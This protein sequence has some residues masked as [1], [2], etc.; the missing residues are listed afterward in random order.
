MER[1]KLR[2]DY[3]AILILMFSGFLISGE[4][5]VEKIE[6]NITALKK[7][8]NDISGLEARKTGYSRVRRDPFVPLITPRIVSVSDSEPVEEA[9]AQEFIV[10]G[11]LH[12]SK[13]SFAI[14][15][16]EVKAEGDFIENCRIRRIIDDNVLLQCDNTFFTVSMAGQE[17]KSEDEFEESK[18]SDKAENELPAKKSGDVK[19]TGKIEAQ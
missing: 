9:K 16:G 7:S 17:V 11:I 18:P 15:N 13:K 3:T 4:L 2:F 6:G 5:D 8:L 10:S 12:G 1:K 14:I 19:N